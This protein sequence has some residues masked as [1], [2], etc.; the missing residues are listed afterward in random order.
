[1]N[2]LPI[3]DANPVMK[4]EISKKYIKIST[5]APKLKADAKGGGEAKYESE[6]KYA[7]ERTVTIR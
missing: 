3:Q 1:M 2:D 4:T 7:L 6:I 5:E